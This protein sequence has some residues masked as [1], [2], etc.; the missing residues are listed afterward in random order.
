MVS[1]TEQP[2]TLERLNQQAA[3]EAL[4]STPGHMLRW[5]EY[6]RDFKGK[7]DRVVVT[8]DEEG[9]Y[10]A[11]EVTDGDERC[12]LSTNLVT[13]A[14]NKETGTETGDLHVD[15]NPYVGVHDLVIEG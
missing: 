4:S 6:S 1:K 2:I 12:T 3:L 10:L 15:L 14:V 8:Y 5:S 9:G 11:I 13:L 7:V